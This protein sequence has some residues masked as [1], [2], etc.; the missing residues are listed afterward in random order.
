M[1]D[2]FIKRNIYDIQII[3]IC[4]TMI[5]NSISFNNKIET[6]EEKIDKIENTIKNEQE[7]NN[8]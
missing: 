4:I 8:I 1:K 6:I 5:Y 2:T 3:A 7:K